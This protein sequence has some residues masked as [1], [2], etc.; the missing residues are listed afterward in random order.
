M[1]EPS[2]AYSIAVIPGDGIGP[3]V[4]AEGVKVLNAAAARNDF[5]IAW[6]YYPYGADYYLETGEVLSRQS[7]AELAS[8]DAIYFGA[9]GDERV[10]PGTLE[11][12]LVIAIRMYC[13][14]YVNLRP[15]KLLAGIESPLRGKSPADIDFIVVRENTEDFYVALGAKILSRCESQEF[16]LSRKLYEAE[17]S[18]TVNHTSQGLAYQIGVLTAEGT[19]RILQYSFE[20]ARRRRGKI[21]L[22]DKA[23]VLT[24]MYSYWREIGRE[25]AADY[26]DVEMDYML[27]DAATMWFVHRPELFDVVVAPN[28]FGDILTD[29]GA[30]IQ[31][32]LGTAAG[33]NI[34]PDGVSMFEP[35]HGSAPPLKGQQKA[36]PV[37]TIWAGA[38]MLETLGERRAATQVMEALEENLA[39]GKKRTPDLGGTSTTAEVGDDIA[40]SL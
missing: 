27:I 26:P 37:A 33:A 19:R 12:G 6:K 38:M 2:A 16:H 34:C 25:V 18:V 35:I 20:L 5:G 17:F 31:G 4:I 13:D 36:N 9:C 11:K 10:A 30:A 28:M 23:N 40:E 29:L 14:Q 22:I 21:T 7:L 24:E 39:A 1:M 32:G 3:E 8:H 15:I